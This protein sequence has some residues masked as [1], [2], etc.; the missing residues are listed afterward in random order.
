MLRKDWFLFQLSLTAAD[1]LL[2]LLADISCHFNVDEEKK[3]T[4]GAL[5]HG[6]LLICGEHVEQPP[7]DTA[8]HNSSSV[9]VLT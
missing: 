3:Q 7:G 2:Y 4:P 1:R 6:C 9:Q 8:A 5:C